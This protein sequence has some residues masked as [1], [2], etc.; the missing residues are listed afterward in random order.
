MAA[1]TFDIQTPAFNHADLPE[2]AARWVRNQRQLLV[3]ARPCRGD[4][5]ETLRR[6]VEMAGLG[7]R[8]GG[9]QGTLVLSGAL[10]ELQALA[11]GW[12]SSP[13]PDEAT[14]GRELG[15]GLG[16][17]TT[18]PTWTTRIGSRSFCWGQRT[19]VMGIVNVTPDSF[20]GDG[21]LAASRVRSD[22]VAAMAAEQALALVAQGADIIDVGGESTRPGAAPVDVDAELE[23]VIPAIR[24]IRRQ[25]DVAISV[26][27]FKA[28][29]AQAALDAG[30]DMIND[31]WGLRMDPEM[32][33]VAARCQA[34]VILM[35]N[36]SRTGQ[37]ALAPHLGGRYVG[38]DYDDLLLDILEELQVQIE[39]A[40]A[41]GVPRE[42]IVVDP[43]LGFGKTV[44]QNLALLDRCGALR[45]LGLPI[46]LG[47]SR[48]SFIGY[49][50]GLP[51][52]QR[53]YGTVASLALAI[54]RGGVDMVRVH[55]VNAAVQ[56]TRMAD[57]IVGRGASPAPDRQG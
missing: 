27:T 23:R 41:W 54:A 19:Y 32:G 26:D 51:P 57:A 11:E 21:L 56:A 37:A 30:A 10:A 34:P 3:R 16:H 15:Q 4:D 22:D 45:V 35:H 8:Q 24:A 25:S 28:Q 55:D 52:E 38:V 6:I 2:S 31:V 7:P 1:Y 5:W 46:L 53:V 50:L 14:L 13:N 44:E 39:Q 33:P 42:R 17:A 12:E 36:R 40:L 43:G 49:T 9:A 48:K 18:T 20:S 29:V 47:P